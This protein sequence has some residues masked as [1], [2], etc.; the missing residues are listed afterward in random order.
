MG[1]TPG[2]CAHLRM[3]RQ[4]GRQLARALDAEVPPGFDDDYR[5]SDRISP[6][7]AA[8]I[9]VS[10]AEGMAGGRRHLVLGRFGF[11]RA[12]RRGLLFNARA[13]TVHRLPLT[14][15]ISDRFLHE[16]AAVTERPV[17]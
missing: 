4:D 7:E 12:D 17:E 16:L 14:G 1:H 6:S 15:E 13:E 9:L 3:T 10:T 5:G 11:A 2:V 8:W